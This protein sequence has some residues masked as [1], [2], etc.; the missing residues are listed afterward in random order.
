MKI[1][2]NIRQS[3][4]NVSHSNSPLPSGVELTERPIS[5]CFISTSY[6]AIGTSNGSLQIFDLIT[7]DPIKKMCLNEKVCQGFEITKV[8][9]VTHAEKTYLVCSTWGDGVHFLELDQ[10]LL[11][12]S[13]PSKSIIKVAEKHAFKDS[14]I[15]AIEELD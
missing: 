6:V 5:G 3:S 13:D 1:Q 2:K 9:K 8:I 7:R 14:C 12:S 10:N 11:S 4:P 15:S